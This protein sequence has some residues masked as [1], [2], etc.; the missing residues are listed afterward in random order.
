MQGRLELENLKRFEVR[1][2]GNNG[3]QHLGMVELVRVTNVDKKSHRPVWRV[4]IDIA[5]VGD[6][7]NADLSQIP[8][9]ERMYKK[10]HTH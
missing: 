9:Y 8:Y 2:V 7:H 4:E 6:F 10:S 1:T 3:L 5:S